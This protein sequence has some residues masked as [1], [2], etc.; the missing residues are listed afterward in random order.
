MRNIDIFN[1][2]VA[3]IFSS[4]YESFPAEI[5]INKHDIA[6]VIQGYYLDSES[7]QVHKEVVDNN[8]RP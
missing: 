3:E 6:K 5:E 4:C 7:V 2:T 8:F 1:L